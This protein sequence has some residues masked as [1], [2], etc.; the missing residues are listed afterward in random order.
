[1]TS[2]LVSAAVETPLSIHD[3]SPPAVEEIPLPPPEL[4]GELENAGGNGEAPQNTSSASDED[5]SEAEAA[6]ELDFVGEAH[7][8]RIVL[9]H[10]FRREGAVVDVVTV[11]RLRIGEVDEV[12]RRVGKKKVSLFDVYAQMTGLPASVL[13]GLIDED[14]DAVTD[15]AYRFLPRELKTA[16]A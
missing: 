8:N 9:K 10:P 4:W 11:R 16:G 12:L 7:Q 14:G 5:T 15:A 1:M 2:K 3:A 13:R 6:E